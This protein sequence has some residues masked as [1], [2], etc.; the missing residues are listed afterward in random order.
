MKRIPIAIFCSPFLAEQLQREVAATDATEGTLAAKLGLP[1][2]FDPWMPPA[3]FDVGYSAAEVRER[4]A[5]IRSA[6]AAS[7][8]NTQ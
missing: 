5:R 6:E 7:K 3:S 4:V 1:L 8:A 2:Y